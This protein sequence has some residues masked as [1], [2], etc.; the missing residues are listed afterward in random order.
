[1]GISR[2]SSNLKG[3]DKKDFESVVQNSSMLLDRLTEILEQ[4]VTELN[5]TS[6]ADYESASWAF[7]QADRNGQV[8]AFKEILLLTNRKGRTS[9]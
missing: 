8:R 5:T 3:S 4:R 2:W 6:K 1:M 7:K 9:G